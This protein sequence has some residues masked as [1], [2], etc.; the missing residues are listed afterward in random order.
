MSDAATIVVQFGVAPGADAGAVGHLSAEVDAREDGLNGGQ[1]EFAPGAQ[2]YI[3]V[4]RTANV[5]IT[6]VEVSA[7]T[8]SAQGATLV[9]IEEELSFED[10]N[11][12]TLQKP[13]AGGALQSAEWLGA[14]LGALTLQADKLTVHAAA[15]GTA[16]C[17]AGYTAEPDVYRLQA[18]ASI[19]GSANFPIL[20]LFKGVAA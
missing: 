18:P 4:Y 11:S 13:A 20:V 6:G 5:T 9:N 1:V 14:E 17:R 7:G 15:K 3:L 19:N 2:V 8:I 16:V 12:A 10:A